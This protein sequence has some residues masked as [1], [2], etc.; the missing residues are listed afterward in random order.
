NKLWTMYVN[1]ANKYDDEMTGSWRDDME[2]VLIFV[3]SLRITGLFS[4]TIATFLAESYQQLQPDSGSQTVALLSQISHQLAAASGSTN[5]TLPP[6]AKNPAIQSDFKAPRTAVWVNALWFI[7][8]VLNIKCALAATLI[9]Q[10]ARR[11]EQMAHHPSSN[12]CIRA[13]IRFYVAECVDG[14]MVSSAL[15]TIPFILH[16]SVF[17]FLTG[18][19]IFLSAINGTVMVAVLVYCRITTV[20]S[21]RITQDF[22]G[23]RR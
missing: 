14:S 19:V 8:L 5:F 3:R 7:S 10:W 12:A 6:G 15:N 9:R 4:A 1:K 21:S 18:L 11:Y 16:V 22:W 23:P 20:S 17:L 13:R 2:G